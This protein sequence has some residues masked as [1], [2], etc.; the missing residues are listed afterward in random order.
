M[1]HNQ[2]MK[3]EDFFKSNLS[4]NFNV[5]CIN[6]ISGQTSFGRRSNPAKYQDLIMML[7]GVNLIVVNMS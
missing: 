4:Q 1:I 5:K 2:F 7:L 6:L 3:C